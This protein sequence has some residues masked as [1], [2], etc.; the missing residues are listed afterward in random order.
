MKNRLTKLALFSAAFLTLMTSQIASSILGPLKQAFPEA[1]DTQIQL[2]YTIVSIA[3]FFTSF[4]CG[5]LIRR[6]KRALLFGIVCFTLGGLLTGTAR[7]L[8]VL[9][10]FRVVTGIGSGIITPV[11]N[12]LFS[13]ITP[14]KERP[15]TLGLIGTISQAGSICASLGAGLLAGISWRS[16]FVLFALGLVP[17]C[18]IPRNLQEITVERKTND[19]LLTRPVPARIFVLAVVNFFFGCIFSSSF[20]NLSIWMTENGISS[21][22]GGIAISMAATG[23]MLFCWLTPRFLQWMKGF[24]VSFFWLMIAAMYL[25]I[26]RSP[27]AF[28]VGVAMFGMGIFGGMLS[29]SVNNAALQ[30]ADKDNSVIHMSIVGSANML[31]GFL[32]PYVFSLTGKILGNGSI[33]FGFQINALESLGMA[34]ACLFVFDRHMSRRPVSSR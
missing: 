9:L 33:P 24:T 30:T 12:G 16:A 17:L 32:C 19:N 27:S 4:L 20:T 2:V 7:S 31:G 5:F 15:R 11:V 1:H 8:P 6:K 14:P 34:V 29:V 26:S 22:K 10:L 23:A 25:L 3:S 28:S 18:L 21:G 13:D